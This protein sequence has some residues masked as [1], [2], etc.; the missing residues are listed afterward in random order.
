M[1]EI[2]YQILKFLDSSDDN[3]SMVDIIRHLQS[4]DY[5]ATAIQ[6]HFVDLRALDCID[7]GSSQGF[8]HVTVKGREY[9]DDYEY[10][11]EHDDLYVDQLITA[12][13]SAKYSMII[14]II[15]VSIAALAILANVIT[16]F[17]LHKPQ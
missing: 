3:Q 13:K 9:I 14:S 16:E 2:K 5:E 7:N 10:R 6:K 17:L 12:K 8:V 15:S 4:L 1:N 11:K